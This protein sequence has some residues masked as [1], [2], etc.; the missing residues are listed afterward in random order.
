MCGARGWSQWDTAMAHRGEPLVQVASPTGPAHVAQGEGCTDGACARTVHGQS[1][2]GTVPLQH[3]PWA[4]QQ[5]AEPSSERERP[6]HVEGCGAANSTCAQAAKQ[7]AILCRRHSSVLSKT[8]HHQRISDTAPQCA[9]SPQAR[10]HVSLCG[11]H[12]VSVAVRVD[13]RET[14]QHILHQRWRVVSHGNAWTASPR[15]GAV[16]GAQA[17]QRGQRVGAQAGGEGEA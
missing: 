6:A 17:S 4:T 16:P 3:S 2:P 8:T 5:W 14:P 10:T 13:A 7:T 9:R 1:P 15:S 11:T 12:W